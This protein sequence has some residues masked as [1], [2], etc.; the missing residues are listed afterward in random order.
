MELNQKEDSNISYKRKLFLIDLK[1][2]GQ[3]FSLVNSFKD[4]VVHLKKL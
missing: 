4:F 3:F 2:I 1:E